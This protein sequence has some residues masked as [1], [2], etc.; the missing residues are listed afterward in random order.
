MNRDDVAAAAA[1]AGGAAVDAAIVA[2]GSRNARISTALHAAAWVGFNVT[3]ASGGDAPGPMMTAANALGI[4]LVFTGIASWMLL[5]EWM[6]SVASVRSG[7]GVDVPGRGWIWLSWLIPIADLFSPAKTMRRLAQGAVST[8]LLLAWWLPW[9]VATLLVY[10]RDDA[11]DPAE[12]ALVSAAAIVV[13]WFALTR[14]ID[15]VSS[16]TAQAPAPDSAAAT[17]SSVV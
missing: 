10:A 3:Y 6:C 15:Q 17:S 7:Q 1:D 16:A 11:V 9:L 14:I 12:P 5:S 13:S 8:R 4:A 2:R